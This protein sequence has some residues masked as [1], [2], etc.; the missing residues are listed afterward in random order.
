[1]AFW[2]KKTTDDP[3]QVKKTSF[4]VIIVFVFVGLF[5]LALFGGCIA[6][7]GL[8]QYIKEAEKSRAAEAFNVLK[9]AQEARNKA[10]FSNWN[11][12]QVKI[13]GAK[14]DAGDPRFADTPYFRFR[15]DAQNIVAF[16]KTAVPGKY[17]YAMGINALSV[18]CILDG[19]NDFV[20]NGLCIGYKTT[21]APEFFR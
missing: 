18:F 8:P 2:K 17:T 21:V 19:E 4:A 15:V 20:R 11:D 13:P 16:R 12:A 10:D 6:A 9:S 7:V 14:I 5:L 1:M 3:S